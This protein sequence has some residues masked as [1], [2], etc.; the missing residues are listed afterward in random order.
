MYPTNKTITFDNFPVEDTTSSGSKW[1]ENHLQAC[2]VLVIPPL[3]GKHLD[4][5][6]PQLTELKE[7]KFSSDDFATALHMNTEEMKSLSAANL[8]HDG[9]PLGAF[10]V[11]L[12]ELITTLEPDSSS[13]VA[14]PP[15]G[16]LRRSTRE[17]PSTPTRKPNFHTGENLNL[18]SPHNGPDSSQE[19]NDRDLYSTPSSY[20]KA[21]NVLVEK[22]ETVAA[23]MAAEFISCVLDEFAYS[24]SPSVNPQNMTA[25]YQ[26]APTTRPI[27][28]APLSCTAQDDGSVVLCSPGR[29][30]LAIVEAKRSRHRGTGN[31]H[32]PSGVVAQQ[33]CE[34]LSLCLERFKK[35]NWEM[36][37]ETGG[38][39][40]SCVSLYRVVKVNKLT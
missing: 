26:T 15:T 37:F 10:F 19:T 28:C 21:K 2:R 11:R 12:K 17:V 29:K 34:M 30:T 36:K 1:N 16:Q 38:R 6:K 22:H 31:T 7:K 40:T 27:E 33:A 8:R 24:P 39:N 9:G 23:G 20:I 18:S 3:K 4:I 14:L 13:D 5:L 35:I 25:Q 32:P